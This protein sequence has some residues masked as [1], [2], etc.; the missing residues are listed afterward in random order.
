[1]EIYPNPAAKSDAVVSIEV[2]AAKWEAGGQLSGYDMLGR[3]VFT[4]TM[5]PFIGTQLI[6]VP[7]SK[8]NYR[9]NFI[10]LLLNDRRICKML[11]IY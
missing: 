1:M 7:I 6:T 2:N 8:F 5:S 4:Q 11:Y 10:E 3:L 9:I